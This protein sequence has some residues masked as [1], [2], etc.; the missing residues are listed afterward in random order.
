MLQNIL[1]LN[2]QFA[3]EAVKGGPGLLCRKSL[4]FCSVCVKPLKLEGSTV[5]ALRMDGF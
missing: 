5:S 3:P 2:T 4:A 1:G